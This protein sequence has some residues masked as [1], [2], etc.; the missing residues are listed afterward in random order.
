MLLLFIAKDQNTFFIVGKLNIEIK[1]ISIN[2][3]VYNTPGKGL[4]SQK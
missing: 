4:I 3:M 2:E 1:V